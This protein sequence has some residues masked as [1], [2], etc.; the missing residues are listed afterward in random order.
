MQLSFKSRTLVR[1]AR[2]ALSQTLLKVRTRV[3]ALVAK[4]HCFFFAEMNS[5]TA[6]LRSAGQAQQS[7]APFAA[8]AANSS[9]SATRVVAFVAKS[10]SSCRSGQRNSRAAIS[11]AR[12]ALALAIYSCETAI[13]LAPSNPSLCVH[14]AIARARPD[15]V[16]LLQINRRVCSCLH[17]R[18]GHLLGAR[19]RVH[20][21]CI[22]RRS[23]RSPCSIDALPVVSSVIAK[24]FE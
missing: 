14:L 20:P 12:A 11:R 4:S 17:H 10:H 7:P 13:L 24:S 6:G 21:S 2:Q 1:S 18:S 9:Q 3:V 23:I 8:S 22:V 19:C 15:S 16:V 5:A